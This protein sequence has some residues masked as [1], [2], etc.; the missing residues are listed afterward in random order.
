MGFL[1]DMSAHTSDLGIELVDL[2]TETLHLGLRRLLA[3]GE[4]RHVNR[5]APRD[6]EFTAQLITRVLADLCHVVLFDYVPFSHLLPR[7]LALVHH[8][9]I[10][11]VS[12]GLAAGVPQLVMPMAHDQHDNAA[13]LRRLGVG[14]SIRPSAFHGPNVAATLN[15][16]I[17]S[18]DVASRC[19]GISAKLNGADAVNQACDL[20]EHLVH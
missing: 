14:E 7:S 15:R 16:L 18:A 20:I 1:F 19:Q 10:G 9:G 3:I 11:T 4:F 17:M 2:G 12:Q 13:R 6:I 5:L 8:G